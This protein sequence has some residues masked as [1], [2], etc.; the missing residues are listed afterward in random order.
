MLL[1]LTILVDATLVRVVLRPATVRLP[2]ARELVGASVAA[3]AAS[4][5]AA[6]AVADQG[7]PSRRTYFAGSTCDHHARVTPCGGHRV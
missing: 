6:A 2:R 3:A 7:W 4:A 5:A 1:P